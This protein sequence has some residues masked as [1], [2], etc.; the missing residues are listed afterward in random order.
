MRLLAPHLENENPTKDIDFSPSRIVMRR[1][2]AYEATMRALNQA[3]QQGE[4]N[5]IE[6]VI[7]HDGANDP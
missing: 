4:F 7:L 5:P 6:G 2:A 3:P 1:E